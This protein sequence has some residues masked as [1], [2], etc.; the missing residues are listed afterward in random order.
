M[1]SVWIYNIDIS[2]NKEIRGIRRCVK[3]L[4][5]FYI[6]EDGSEVNYRKNLSDKQGYLNAERCKYLH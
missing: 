3:A 5:C 1:S 2:K 6:W 4:R